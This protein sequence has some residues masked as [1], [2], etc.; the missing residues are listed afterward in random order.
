MTDR[1]RTLLQRAAALVG[2]V[3]ASAA[4]VPQGTAGA[5]TPRAGVAPRAG[6]ALHADQRLR[7]HQARAAAPASAVLKGPDSLRLLGQTYTLRPGDTTFHLRL[8]VSAGSPATEALGFNAYG[9]LIARSQFQAAR[10]G[11]ALTPFFYQLPVPVPLKSLHRDPAGGVDLGIPVNT[12]GGLPITATGVYPVQVFLELD[13]VRV[14]S[15]LTTFLVYAGSDAADLRRLRVAV[16]VGGGP[17]TAPGPRSPVGAGS[18]AATVSV[19][20]RDAGVI[21]SAATARH[22]VPLTLALAPSTVSAMN[23][24]P[25]AER[26][27]VADLRSAAANGDQVLPATEVPVDVPAVVAAGLSG[28]LQALVAEGQKTLQAVLGVTPPTS[29]WAFSSYLSPA[30]ARVLAAQG[31]QQLVV[32]DGNLAQLPPAYLTRTFAQPAQLQADGARL[33]VIGADGE[34]AA[35]LAKAG[36]SPGQAVLVT[37]QLLAE[38]AMIDLERASDLRGVV[39]MAPAGTVPGPTV[40]STLVAGL[41]GNP[42]L[43]A[44]TLDSEFDSVPLAT[45]GSAPMVRRLA[46]WRGP[47]PLAGVAG[48]AGAER[49]VRADRAVFGSAPGAV[50]SYSQRLLDALSS[51]LSPAQRQAEIASVRAGARAQLER[52]RLPTPLASTITSLNAQLPLTLFSTANV[53]ARVDLVL[54]S[55]Q[56]SF[57]P[58]RFPQGSCAPTA[59][60]TEVCQ[61]TLS[62]PATVLQVPISVRTP[63]VFQLAME[64]QTVDGATVLDTSTQTVRSTAVPNVGLVIIVVAAL[65]LGVW[66][67]RNA[68]HGRRA[69]QLVPRPVYEG[70]YDGEYDPEEAYDAGEA[71]PVDSADLDD[72]LPA[73]GSPGTGGPD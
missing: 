7:L 20:Q 52:V 38:L 46:G 59:P 23:S 22:P 43:K 42:L 34:L 21:G 35:Q 61:L 71:G 40:L 13:G 27:A 18:Q 8:Q 51:D 68:R 67:V 56:L 41:E 62:H 36:S 10:D 65:F 28:D 4:L 50:T 55:E 69:R 14:G 60:G 44:V 1:G 2:A 72:T 47:T 29:T 24:G 39:L 30:S 32:P 63:G 70:E 58:R 57:V 19:L 5:L 48:L 11:Q 73:T 31:A 64:L 53:P 15:P 9:P 25:P 12:A 33:S 45:Q 66:W 54:S 49:E 16:V 3:L 26:Q 17:G 6:A 37:D